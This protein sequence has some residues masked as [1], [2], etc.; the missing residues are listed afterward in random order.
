MDDVKPVPAAPK[1][2]LKWNPKAGVR[3]GAPARDLTA[4]E[5]HAWVSKPLYQEMLES[6]A[7]SVVDDPTPPKAQAAATPAAASPPEDK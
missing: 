2:A 6:G 1:K 4:D 3:F 7:Y 5:V